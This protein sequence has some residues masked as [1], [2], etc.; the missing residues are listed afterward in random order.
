MKILVIHGPNLNLL[1]TREP[2][3][4]GKHSLARID[5]MLVKDGRERGIEVEAF[6]SNHEGAIIDRIQAADGED[7]A[8]IV[9]NPGA[10]THTSLAIADA[11]RAVSVPV[12][13][14]HLSNLYARGAERARS[15]TAA[16]CRG[17]VAGF[18]YESYLLGMEAAARLARR[19]R[20]RGQARRAGSKTRSRKRRPGTPR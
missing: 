14:V 19:P 10:Y 7:V 1:G 11:V 13:E 12:V 6:Q 17:L 8:A 3:I 18:G 5:A 15:I 9:L 2:E 16:A 20:R 4:Y